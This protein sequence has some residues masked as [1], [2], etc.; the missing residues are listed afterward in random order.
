MKR[1]LFLIEKTLVNNIDFTPIHCTR[2]PS[3]RRSHTDRNYT[4]MTKYSW[5]KAVIGAL[6]QVKLPL[7]CKQDEG[8]AI[9]KSNFT[10]ASKHANGNLAGRS[11]NDREKD[12]S[13]WSSPL[14]ANESIKQQPLRDQS[15][16]SHRLPRPI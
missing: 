14:I 6:S 5:T 16:G 1:S 12:L 2:F 4:S 9:V 13:N 15:T 10:L 3:F 7:R 8:E 11:L